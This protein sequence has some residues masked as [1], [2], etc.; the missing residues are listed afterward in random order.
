VI[1]TGVVSPVR[2]GAVTLAA[3]LTT[4]V[5]L[6]VRAGQP[7]ALATTLLVS[8]GSMQTGR[9]AITI[10][11]GVLIIAAIGEPMRRF[12]LMYTQLR[13]AAGKV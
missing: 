7:A 8:L 12:R 6:P 2:L 5:T 11:A 9:D 4:I 13:P 1:S 3:T 10:I